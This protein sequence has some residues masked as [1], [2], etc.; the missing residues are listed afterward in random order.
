VGSKRELGPI[1]DL[2]HQVEEDTAIGR[3]PHTE[4]TPYMLKVVIDE[5]APHFGDWR[6]H[7]SSSWVEMMMEEDP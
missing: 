1:L 2:V 3:H 5:N 7:D 6:C 4:S